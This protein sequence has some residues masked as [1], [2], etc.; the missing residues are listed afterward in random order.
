MGKMRN[1]HNILSENLKRERERT[2]GVDGFHLVQ[3]GSCGGLL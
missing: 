1:V 3:D 2:V